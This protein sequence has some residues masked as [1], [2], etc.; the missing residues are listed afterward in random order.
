MSA[1]NW[2]PVYNFV[3]QIKSQYI[4]KYKT[5]TYDICKH[6]DEH[7]ITKEVTC[8]E[9]WIIDLDVFK[10]KNIASL[11]QFNQS[12]TLILIRYGKFSDVFGGESEV[13]NDTLWELHDGIYRECR[14]IVIDVKNEE[15]VLCPYKKF[16]NLNENEEN[17]IEVV[18]EKIKNCNSF[19]I[20]D[21][22]DGSMQSARYYRDQIIM[23][24]S[25]A[26][27][28]K[29]SW[30][31]QSGYNMLTSQLN[32]VKMIKENSD[33]TFIFEYIS[34][35]DAHVVNYKKEDEG[36]YLIGMR[37]VYTGEQLSYNKVKEYAIKYN[38]KMT[39]I[40]N[41]T[42]EEIM[43]D[44]KIYKSH[45]M[46]GYVI[47]LDGHLIKIKID[48]YV[49]MHKVLS[50]ISS[51][52]LIIKHI[53][54]NSFDDL[55]SK[56]PESYRWRVMKVAEIVFQYIKDMDKLVNEYYIKA[57][58]EDRKEFM[59]WVDQNVPAGLIGYVKNKYLNKEYN[60]IK[61]GNEKSPRYRKLN[62]MGVVNYNEVFINEV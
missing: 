61:S 47:N 49:E 55:L 12:D 62:E 54:D 32:Y 50:A 21:K 16:H 30:R 46:E 22:L 13:T 31:L 58:K 25:Q 3:M 60:Y 53:A 11:L 43:N 38:V 9:K 2:N 8:L 4:E 23:S 52:N 14:S 18:I 44:T 41:K 48:D 33:Y 59:I 36:L 5:I 7:N 27:N 15:I 37:N 17:Q 56:V 1:F 40:L 10:Y 42:F 51:I 24:G 28:M 35:K 19:E 45:E 57:P 34:L 6:T 26:I 29:N 20:T 39:P